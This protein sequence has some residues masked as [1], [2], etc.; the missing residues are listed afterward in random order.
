MAV[1]SRAYAMIML[2]RNNDTGVT[3]FNTTD[4]G[5]DESSWRELEESGVIEPQDAVGNT[6]FNAKKAREFLGLD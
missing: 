1:N 5:L 4:I 6:T 3:T 2:N